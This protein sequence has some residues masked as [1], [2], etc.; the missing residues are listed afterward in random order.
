[1][2]IVCSWE[3]LQILTA[4]TQKFQLCFLWLRA[5]NDFWKLLP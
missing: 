5:R 2:G 3:V 4:S 1:M